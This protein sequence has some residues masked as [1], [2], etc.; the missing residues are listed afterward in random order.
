LGRRW[1]RRARRLWLLRDEKSFDLRGFG[2]SSDMK[3]LRNEIV[4]D[5]EE[6]GNIISVMD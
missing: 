3:A 4:G 5:G 2:W 6:V 1:G